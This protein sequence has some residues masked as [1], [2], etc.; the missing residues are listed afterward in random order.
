MSNRTAAGGSVTA[1]RVP[2]CRDVADQI[3]WCR[4]CL[5]GFALVLRTEKCPICDQPAD[6]ADECPVPRVR[7]RVT[8]WDWFLL[9]ILA[10]DPERNHCNRPWSPHPHETSDPRLV[11]VLAQQIDLSQ[12]QVITQL[13]A[14]D[15]LKKLGT[16]PAPSRPCA[17]RWVA[18]AGGHRCRCARDHDA[19][20]RHLHRQL[21][22][23]EEDRRRHDHASART[24]WTIQRCH[25]GCA[26]HPRFR[27][28]WRNWRS[29]I[30]S[31]RR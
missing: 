14:M 22:A 7:W 28:G 24:D 13:S 4:A 30:P 26:S 17:C 23:A 10:I 5:R 20:A 25:Q 15:A 11:G 2:S 3:Q 16:V 6:W 31:R 12:L 29:S 9:L 18:P 27:A 19:R 21:R 8:R 1:A